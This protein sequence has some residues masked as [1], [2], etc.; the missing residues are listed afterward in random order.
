MVHIQVN[1]STARLCNPAA[2]DLHE[3]ARLKFVTF[4]I[5]SPGSPFSSSHFSPIV[6][7]ASSLALSV[8]FHFNDT[9][10]N[11]SPGTIIALK[12]PWQPSPTYQTSSYLMSLQ[13][14]MSEDL[15]NFAR[16]SKRVQAVVAKP[17]LRTHRALIRKYR[18]FD[19][20]LYGRAAV[21]SLLQDI[22]T[23]PH[24]AHYVREARVD[25]QRRFLRP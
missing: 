16:I 20:R 1:T 8:I 23:T 21:A 7:P 13:Q 22:L 24:I 10:P 2:C 3:Q 11:S 15:E 25:F 6:L 9:L 4:T 17:L 14:C 5:D 18:C 12:K 19:N